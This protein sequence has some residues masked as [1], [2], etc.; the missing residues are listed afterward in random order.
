MESL[1]VL[2]LLLNPL[3][4]VSSFYDL[5]INIVIRGLYLALIV[6]LMIKD[7]KNIKLL[8]LLLGFG[9]V[10]ILFQRFY[11][12]FSF[13]NSISN[14][15]RFLYLPISILFFKNFCFK[16]YDKRK[17]LAEVLLVYLGTYL[18]SYVLG[19]GESAY[20]EGDG[21]EGFK[22]I[23]S[24]INEFSAIALCLIP[25]AVNYLKEKKNYIL[26]SLVFILTILTSLLIGT[27]VLFFGLIIF[28][29][30]FLYQ[31][32][33]LF[34]KR[35]RIEKVLIISLLVFI[36]IISIYLFTKTRIYN[37]MVTQRS[38]FKPDSIFEYINNVIF[39]NRLSFIE[40]NFNYFIKSN[41]MRWLL[42]IGINIYDVKM[43]EID[44]FD[45]IFRY[46]IIGMGL[47]ILI[48]SKIRLKDISSSEK[49]SLILL[50]LISLTSGHVLIYPNVC[51]YIALILSKNKVIE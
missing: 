20:Y 45:I 9:I 49:F 13:I 37:N 10:E 8:G 17:V 7:K 34:L 39:N 24:S 50:I 5:P 15:F 23:F 25:I 29:I 48:F 47:F 33:E 4:D 2:F 41:P 27:K 38:F 32:K 21:K 40:E 43:V 11:L 46:G 35:K 42:G 28:I 18:M 30:Y 31:E 14:T 26:L 44:I 19:T 3:L 12:S 6:L 1:I 22:G 51:I 16:K 36:S